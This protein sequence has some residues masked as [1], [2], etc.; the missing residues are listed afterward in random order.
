VNKGGHPATL[1]HLAG[2]AAAV[3]HGVYAAANRVPAPRAREVAE[4]LMAA[5]HVV[6]LDQVA[7]EEIGALVALVEALGRRDPASIAL[8]RA[9]AR[10]A[11]RRR[12]L[13]G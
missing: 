2:N 4:A 8:Q 9:R 1:R 5:P 3:R 10:G 6:P 13:A 7:A 12:G 11:A